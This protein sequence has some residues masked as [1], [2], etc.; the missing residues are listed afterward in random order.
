M[1]ELDPGTEALMLLVILTAM[2]HRTIKFQLRNCILYCI[3]YRLIDLSSESV[4][5]IF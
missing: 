2:Y 3:L 4:F 1:K 5:E